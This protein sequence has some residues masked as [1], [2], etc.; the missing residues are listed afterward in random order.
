MK[1]QALKYDGRPSTD[2]LIVEIT[3]VK[4]YLVFILVCERSTQNI[5][6][7]IIELFW[8]S[9]DETHH[10]IRHLML[11]LRAEEVSTENE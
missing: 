8:K 11:F 4:L 2:D 9:R 10:L 1:V 3:E 6:P 7:S 5:D